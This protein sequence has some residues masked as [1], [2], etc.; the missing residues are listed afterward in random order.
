MVS[1]PWVFVWQVGLLCPVLWLLGLVW[2]QQVTALGN[3]LDWLVGLFGCG[4]L[5]SITFAP[6]SM[7]ARWYGWATVCLIAAL[8]AVRS[9]ATTPERRRSL[10]IAQAYLSL[11]FILMSL[12]LWTTQTLIPELD[13]L[14]EFQAVGLTLG[15]DFSRLELRNWAPIGHQ[16]YVAGYLVLALPLLISLAW[17]QTKWRRWIWAIGAGFGLLAL[18]TTSSR[19]GWLG[20]AAEVVAAIGLLA[21]RSALPR[22]WITALSLAGLSGL[23]GLVLVNNRLRGA[24]AGIFSSQAS[25]QASGELAYRLITNTTGWQMGISHWFTGT[26]PGSV[27]LLYQ[28]YRP[29]WAG[30]DGEWA[31]QLHSTPAQIWAELGIWAALLGL[32]TIGLIIPLIW[33]FLQTQAAANPRSR[34]ISLVMSLVISLVGYTVVSLTDYQLDNLSISGTIVIYLAVLAAECADDAVPI[35]LSVN[36]SRFTTLAGVG[37]LLTTLIWLIPIQRAWMLSSQG[38][39]ALARQDVNGFVQAL[40]QA[41]Q[42]APQEP[43]YLHQLGWNLG[44]L[45]LQTQSAPVQ[46]ATRTD[47]IAWLQRSLQVSPAQEFASTNLAWLVLDRDPAAAARLFAHSAQLIPTKRGVFYGLGLSLLA[48]AKPEAAMTAL[49]LEALRDPVFVTSPIWKLPQL[50][51]LYRSVLDRLTSRYTTLLTA[52]THPALIAQ[53]QQS[54]GGV[55]WWTG[56]LTGAHADLAPAG[57]PLSQTVLAI[58]AGQSIPASQLE[59]SAGQ[60]AIA[61]W[62]NPTQ[63]ATLLQQAWIF[64]THQTPPPDL[65]QQL[66]DSMGRSTSLDQWLKQNAPTRPYRRERAGFGVLSRHIDGPIPIDFPTVIDNVPLTNFFP[67]L[68]PSFFYA[69]ELDQALQPDRDA[70]IRQVLSQ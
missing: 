37:I 7:Q 1:W 54:R 17:T 61:A 41:Q 11:A 24:I 28:Q 64:A 67:D 22:R 5:V 43:Y 14:R 10:L 33:R 34:V 62:L 70:L 16:N 60:A 9:W 35:T 63:R 27:P 56:D 8:Y 21:W 49:T 25:S 45:S 23:V 42:L 12:T 52:A 47:A 44:Q 19:A 30:R 18:Y 55:R 15:Y 26:G 65:L 38:F 40:T 53:L 6:F 31:Y 32:S 51:P 58:A 36:P 68:V 4:L 66:V 59:P 29:G 2:Q 57:L 39:A 13:R 50:Q 3:R 20:L 48:Q 46:Q 69:P